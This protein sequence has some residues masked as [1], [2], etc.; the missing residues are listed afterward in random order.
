MTRNSKFVMTLR[1][2][3]NGRYATMRYLGFVC[4]LLIKPRNNLESVP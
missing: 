4:L 1:P 3:L 2:L